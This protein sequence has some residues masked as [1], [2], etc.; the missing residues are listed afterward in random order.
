L[1]AGFSKHK[2]RVVIV[3]GSSFVTL[4]NPIDMQCYDRSR[5]THRVNV[6]IVDTMLLAPDGGKSLDNLRT[7]IGLKKLDL[8]QGYRECL[9]HMSPVYP[10]SGIVCKSGSVNEIS[11]RH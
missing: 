5:N 10:A 6:R 11:I 7:I 3:Q 4:I 2:R 9:Q 8:T 1:V